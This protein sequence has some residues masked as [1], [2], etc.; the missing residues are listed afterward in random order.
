MRIIRGL[1]KFVR[2][3]KVP[4]GIYA[5][6]PITADSV[7]QPMQELLNNTHYIYSKIE[8]L[9]DKVYRIDN[10]STTAPATTN[11]NQ[12]PVR[13]IVPNGGVFYMSSTEVSK[14]ITIQYSRQTF[15]TGEIAFRLSNMDENIRYATHVQ[16]ITDST[17]TVNVQRNGVFYGHTTFTL[18]V[19]DAAS[20]QRLNSVL[21]TLRTDPVADAFK[22]RIS[23]AQSWFPAF[24]KG[25]QT[26]MTTLIQTIPVFNVDM[27]AVSVSTLA[28]PVTVRN[29][30]S[31]KVTVRN[32]DVRLQAVLDREFITSDTILT[33]Q[34]Q[35]FGAPSDGASLELLF[36]GMSPTA[37]YTAWVAQV[38]VGFSPTFKF[39]TNASAGLYDLSAYCEIEDYGRLNA[40]AN[41]SY[42]MPPLEVRADANNVITIPS[43]RAV[44][45]IKNKNP[46]RFDKI[47]MGV[48]RFHSDK[49]IFKDSD[50]LPEIELARTT[51]IVFREYTGYSTPGFVTYYIGMIPELKLTIDPS[52]P[53]N[54]TFTIL[55]EVKIMTPTGLGT[56]GTV[57]SR[58]FKFVYKK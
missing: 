12:V 30:P 50:R 17:L 21:I 31:V 9:R 38:N 32:T 5:D 24:F 41:Y 27:S 52:T 43:F 58:T 26:A 56:I 10:T 35:K 2:D 4:Y 3:L 6:E 8:A 25:T 22:T 48:S 40:L 34:L 36:E 37:G 45:A 1:P 18:E 57:N 29:I 16:N 55:P 28:I 11:I 13:L 7:G 19:V 15:T 53:N 39:T 51:Q 23:R 49:M 46:T 47:K 33:L 20:G 14:L 42:E 54:A 44:V